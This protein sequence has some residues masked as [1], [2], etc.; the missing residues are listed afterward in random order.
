MWGCLMKKTKENHALEMYNREVD[1]RSFNEFIFGKHDAYRARL[2]YGVDV[3]N[4]DVL[5][6]Y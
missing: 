2:D 1:L 4:E 5:D 3:T 6:S